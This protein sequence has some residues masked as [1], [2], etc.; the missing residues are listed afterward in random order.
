MALG[1]LPAGASCL[2]KASA[3]TASQAQLPMLSPYSID[4][5]EAN[6]MV[7]TIYTATLI[8]SYC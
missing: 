7:I 1:A 6:R 4:Q 3:R 2:N 5:W 8:A